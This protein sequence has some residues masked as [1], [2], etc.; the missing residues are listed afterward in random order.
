MWW[1]TNKDIW[2]INVRHIWQLYTLTESHKKSYIKSCYIPVKLRTVLEVILC[3][4]RF[5][6]FDENL[7]SWPPRWLNMADVS[8]PAE[9]S[10]YNH[11]MYT[12]TWWPPPLVSFRRRPGRLSIPNICT[13]LRLNSRRNC[14]RRP[15]SAATPGDDSSGCDTWRQVV[16]SSRRRLSS[17]DMLLRCT[18]DV[19]DTSRMK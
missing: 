1:L 15:A 3:E 18:V 8:R 17:S 10:S 7:P 2:A 12:G 4:C 14:P 9:H 6:R 13:R 19:I 5:C 16:M 11:L